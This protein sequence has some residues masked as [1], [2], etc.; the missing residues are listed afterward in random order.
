MGSI[1]PREHGSPRVAEQVE[2][3]PDPQVHEQ[4]VQLVHE[5]VHCPETRWLVPKVGRPSNANLVVEDDGD[6]VE[7]MQLCVGQHVVVGHSRPA[8]EGDERAVA[9]LW[10]SDHLVPGAVRLALMHERGRA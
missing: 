1:V 4:V 9:T 6:A 5:E 3:V 10:V 2:V 7:R 8:V